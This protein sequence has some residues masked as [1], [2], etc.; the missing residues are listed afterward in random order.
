MVSQR[1]RLQERVAGESGEPHPATS[2]IKT[3]DLN[4]SEL[5]Q[6][7][8]VAPQALEP[9]VPPWSKV[10]TPETRPTHS[11]MNEPSAPRTYVRREA[12]APSGL[13]PFEKPA[14]SDEAGRAGTVREP[15]RRDLESA[16]GGRW[17]NLIGIIALTVC[18]A[19]FLKVA[20]DKQWVGPGARVSLS[21]IA[22]VTLLFVGWRPRGRGP[23]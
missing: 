7:P 22:C 9:P 12:A 10:E 11:W 4:A 5:V 23:K 16:I 3:E 1:K 14:A 18:V 21:P 20:F 13:Q 19:F 17:V 6:P 8:P 2:Q 15:K